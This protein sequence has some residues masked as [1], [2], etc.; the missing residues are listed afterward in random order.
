MDTLSVTLAVVREGQDA[1]LVQAQLRQAL[2]SALVEARKA[3]KPKGLEV[4]TGAFSMNPRYANPSNRSAAPSIAG[5]TGRAELLIEGRDLPAVAQLVGRL[6]T[7]AVARVGFA[8]SREA[9]ERVEEEV[10]QQ[11]IA[12]FRARADNYSRQFGFGGYQIREVQVGLQDAPVLMARAPMMRAAA[13]P[14][15][16]EALPVE[17]G[18]TAVG[19]SVSGTVQMLR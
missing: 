4:Q 1:A 15:A 9:R 13:A 5:W 6:N 19:V 3:A 7:L 17:A 2:D 10:T 12:R 8:L 16:D 18:K 14:S 11:A